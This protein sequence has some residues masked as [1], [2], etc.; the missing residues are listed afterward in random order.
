M[1]SLTKWW[2]A[3]VVRLEFGVMSV[4][5][6]RVLILCTHNSARSQMAE[7]LLRDIA[8][9]RFEAASAGTEQTEVR[10]EAIEAMR[11]RGIDISHH[12]SKTLNQF[13]GEPWDYV[14]T[15]C[16]QANEACPVFPGAKDRLHWSIDD[17]SRV[18]GEKRQ[19]AFDTAADAIEKH[20]EEWLEASDHRKLKTSTKRGGETNDE[21]Q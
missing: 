1:V 3:G 19:E 15:V 7:G 10:R 18:F 6:E 21:G 8:G 17:P 20:L 13:L 16:D 4:M 2:A 9:D 14:I 11:K 5:K 12:T